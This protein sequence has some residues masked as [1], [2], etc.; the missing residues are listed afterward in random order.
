MGVNNKQRRAAKQRK[1]SRERAQTA[2]SARAGGN[3]PGFHEDDPLRGLRAGEQD[4]WRD[5][6]DLMLAAAVQELIG[7]R[8][9]TAAKALESARSLLLRLQPASPRIVGQAMAGLL[10]RLGAEAAR[11]GWAEGDL[12]E[13]VRRRVGE[14]H[15]GTLQ[16]SAGTAAAGYTPETLASR[17]RV[18]AALAMVPLATGKVS[19]GAQQVSFRPAVS[20]EKA[21]R[22]AK[23]RALLAKAEATSFDEEADALCAKAQELISRHALERLLQEDPAVTTTSQAP[24]V[25]RI[26]LEMPYV[27]AKATLVD[28]VA[29]ANRCRC[30]VTESLGVCSVVGDPSDLESVEMLSTSL[31]VQASRS[32]LRHGRHHDQRGVSR[33]RSFRQSFLAS[34]AIR[35]GRRLREVNQ[36][37]IRETEPGTDLVPVL[38]N[39]ERRVDEAVETMFPHLVRTETAVSNGL[40]WAAGHAAADLAFLDLH[41]QLAP[42]AS[43]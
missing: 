39:Q 6:V 43:S 33:T 1:R 19:T 27:M 22:L 2:G 32:M 42:S 20:P 13:L 37:A 7:R 5:W 16:T 12:E 24:S 34:F 10:G 11:G 8:P 17:M 30:V 21:K 41:G 35:V 23:V 3:A 14:E 25:R 15:L 36:E 31:L 26:W 38:R 4:E 29:Q 18:A 9:A 28:A 40:G